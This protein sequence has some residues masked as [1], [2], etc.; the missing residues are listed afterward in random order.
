M[1][2]VRLSFNL[3]IIYSLSV[4]I[5]SNHQINCEF[6]LI[7][8]AE[9]KNRMRPEILFSAFR[10]SHSHIWQWIQSISSYWAGICPAYF[11]PFCLPALWKAPTRALLSNLLMHSFIHSAAWSAEKRSDRNITPHCHNCHRFRSQKK[12]LYYRRAASHVCVCSCDCVRSVAQ[13]YHPKN[14]N[15]SSQSFLICL[16]DCL[17]TITSLDT[18]LSLTESCEGRRAESRGAKNANVMFETGH[19]R[20]NVR[21]VNP[22][23]QSR[24]PYRQFTH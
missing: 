13:T 10:T 19:M 14:E 16:S 24:Q 5:N 2:N 23:S 9:V 1:L 17:K 6:S 18:D 3:N 7:W 12:R 20:F 11:C 4:V 8:P 21:D 15:T 22:P